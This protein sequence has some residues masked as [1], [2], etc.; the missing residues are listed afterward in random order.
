MDA[1]K[2]GLGAGVVYVLLANLGWSLSG[3]FV[4]SLP[5]LDFWQINCW[6]GYW[7]A[8]ALLAYLV[9]AYGRNVP[10]KFREL[11]RPAMILSA[12]FF[13][14]GTTFYVL[15]LTKISTATVS[16]IGATSPLFTGLLSPWITG[17]RPKLVAWLAAVIALAGMVT[18]VYGGLQHGALIWQLFCLGVPLT[19][20]LQTLMLR[21]YRQYDMMPAICVGGILMFLSCGLISIFID[22]SINAFTIDAQSMF[23]LMAMGPLQ[24]AIPLI[25]YGLGA[26]SVSAITLS[27]LAMVDAVINPFWTWLFRSEI[28]EQLALIGGGIILLAVIL[29]IIGEGYSSKVQRTE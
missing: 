14:V 21:R 8:F 16:V 28:P 24:L 12:F 9:I 26:K 6:R 15:S 4:R 2:Q 20:A 22:R 23:L 19:F 18:I 11:P 3:I 1:T 25:F 17:E 27:L 10:Q 13:A 29:S 7:A 5:S